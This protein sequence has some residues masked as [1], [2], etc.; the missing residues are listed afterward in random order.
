MSSNQSDHDR[1][2]RSQP[3]RSHRYRR[4]KVAV[5]DTTAVILLISAT[6]QAIADADRA[7]D[8]LS[9]HLPWL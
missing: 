9:R 6:C 7:L 3:D 4:S 5:R 1:N 2:R 8:T